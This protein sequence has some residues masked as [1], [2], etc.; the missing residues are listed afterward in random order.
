MSTVRLKMILTAADRVNADSL[1]P[2]VL[3]VISGLDATK[4]SDGS[5]NVYGRLKD[6]DV[7]AT[8]HGK[9]VRVRFDAMLDL[10]IADFDD[11]EPEARSNAVRAVVGEIAQ[12][13]DPVLDLSKSSVIVGPEHVIRSAKDGGGATIVF[14]LRRTAITLQEFSAYWLNSHGQLIS[15]GR[16]SSGLGL[17]YRQTHA[18]SDLTSLA[19]SAAKF[20]SDFV[21]GV[22]EG[23]Y[24][25]G[26]EL[27]FHLT[28]EAGQ[29][30]LADEPNFI[31]HSRS[32]ITAMTRIQQF[33][34]SA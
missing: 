23:D 28:G 5:G 33:Q 9:L 6:A 25:T 4:G 19:A 34:L 17:G 3:D 12:E 29:Q 11:P 10:H 14:L 7:D 18:D 13:L 20:R 8:A 27:I 2:Q 30:A 22:A 16:T 31:D 1:V 21:D 32:A 24:Y 26:A 15:E